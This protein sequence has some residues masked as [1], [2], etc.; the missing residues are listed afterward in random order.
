MN[1]CLYH[2]IWKVRNEGFLG[3]E[4]S[5]VSRTVKLIQEIFRFRVKAITAKNV[6]VPDIEAVT[7][8][9]VSIWARRMP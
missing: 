4:V 2:S 3:A 1:A 8:L 9:R 6:C 7:I 5:T